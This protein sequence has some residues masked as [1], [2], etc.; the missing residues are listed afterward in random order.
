MRPVSHARRATLLQAL[1]EVQLGEVPDER[2]GVRLPV[3]ADGSQTEGCDAGRV[4]RHE[5][6]QQ[7]PATCDEIQTM[8]LYDQSQSPESDEMERASVR[9]PADRPLSRLDTRERPGLTAVDRV[10]EGLPAPE[11]R[12]Q[13]TAIW[14]DDRRDHP[15]GT[16]GARLTAIDVLRVCP[17]CA[18]R[19]GS[20]EDPPAVREPRAPQVAQARPGQIL[21]LPGP[22]GEENQSGR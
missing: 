16:D 14:R 4:R 20:E 19:L 11:N 18:V 17:W 12:S 22:G 9:A 8:E 3:G 15:L 5:L 10:K 2:V 1:D 7:L 21:R 6:V 13:G